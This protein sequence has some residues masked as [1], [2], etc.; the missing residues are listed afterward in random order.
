LEGICYHKRWILECIEEKTSP[1][2]SVRFAGGGAVAD[3]TC[4]VLADVTGK[5]VEAVRNPQNAGA[6]GAALVCG[7][8]LGQ[9]PDFPSAADLVSVVGRRSSCA[10]YIAIM[11]AQYI[12]MKMAN[13]ADFKNRI[14]EYLSAV[15]GGEEIEV[16]KRNVPIARVV[17]IPGMKTNKTVLGVGKGTGRV[18]GDATRPFIPERE[19]GTLREKRR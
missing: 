4:Q 7:I 1:I 15:E 16:R 18:V 12:A 5:R 11:M 3:G 17:P 2:Q 13:I 19:W 10:L 8:A 6:A 14:S 9:V